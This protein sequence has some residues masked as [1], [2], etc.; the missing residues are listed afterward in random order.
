MKKLLAV[1]LLLAA[2]AI[3]WAVL[4]KND[5][6]RVSFARA[7]RQTIAGDDRHIDDGVGGLALADK[8]DV[9]VENRD[10][11]RRNI[12]LR[13]RRYGDREERDGDDSDARKR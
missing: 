4:R 1:L 10:E 11:C 12:S 9:A 6:P 2:G 13:A 5:A 8:H 3:V 7:R